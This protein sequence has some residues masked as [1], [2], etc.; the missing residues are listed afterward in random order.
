MHKPELE[1]LVAEELGHW[2][3]PDSYRVKRVSMLIQ[4]ILTDAYN[5]IATVGWME[6]VRLAGGLQKWADSKIKEIENVPLHD[7]KK[8]ETKA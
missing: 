1:K 7:L 3:I 6:Q 4:H 8:P 5:E 2:T